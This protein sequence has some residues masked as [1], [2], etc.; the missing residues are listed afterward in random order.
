M[1]LWRGSPLHGKMEMG[2][3]AGINDTRAAN[4]RSSSHLLPPQACTPAK[5]VAFFEGLQ[6]MEAVN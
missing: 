1:L 2:G 6:N 4:A 5:R 3:A